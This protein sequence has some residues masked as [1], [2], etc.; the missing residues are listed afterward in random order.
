[1]SQAVSAVWVV[2]YFLR[3][4]SLLKIR[5]FDWRPRWTTCRSIVAT[6]SPMFAMQIAG[7]VMNALLNNQLRWL[8][9][10]VAISTMGIVHAVAMFFAMPIFGLNQGS[11][12]IIGYNYG[13]AKY[14]RVL[15]TLR[16]AILYA[17]CICIVGFVIV[18]NAPSYVVLLFSRREHQLLE[19]G[20]HALRTCLVMFPV[21]GFQI[22]S[23]SYFQAVGKPKHALF[24][25]LSRQVLLLI[26]AILIMPHFFGLD[27][28]WI[29]IPTA[30]FCSAVLT[31]AWLWLELRHLHGR[32]MAAVATKPAP[33]A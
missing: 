24:L 12:P 17:T 30:D 10:D 18:M 14:D 29:A 19:L 1:L 6:G 25:G 22:V 13:A 28:L 2:S 8:G 20:T 31:G 23:A 15:K 33:D 9:G 16:L 11:Q 21:V 4:P 32:H 27:G 5:I 3:G 26:P 7:S